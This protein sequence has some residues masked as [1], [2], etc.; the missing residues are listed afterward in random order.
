M[1]RL[2]DKLDKEIDKEYVEETIAKVVD[3]LGGYVTDH[4]DLEERYMAKYEYSGYNS[5]KSEH[6]TFLND[7]HKSKDLLESGSKSAKYYLHS[8]LTSWLSSHIKAADKDMAD[9]L[10]EKIG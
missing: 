8:I 6:A 5:H 10:R 1:F 3:F 4:F 9:Y 2:I 7:F